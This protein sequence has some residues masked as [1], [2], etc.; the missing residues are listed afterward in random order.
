[1]TLPIVR[2]PPP[3]ADCPDVEDCVADPSEIGHICSF[4]PVCGTCIV[5]RVNAT[6]RGLLEGTCRSRPDRGT[7]ACTAAICDG[8]IPRAGAPNAKGETS[9]DADRRIVSPAS[10]ARGRAPR[11][12]GPVAPTRLKLP[13]GPIG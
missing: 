2:P 4:G 9:T 13:D 1:M 7:F 10:T 5:Y 8:Y 3:A 11:P 12:P 6:A